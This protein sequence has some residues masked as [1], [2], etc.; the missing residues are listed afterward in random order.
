MSRFRV[1]PG[2]FACIALL[3][4]IAAVV[5]LSSHETP[6]AASVV[7]PAA[8]QSAPVV[9]AQITSSPLSPGFEFAGSV[10]DRSAGD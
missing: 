6:R 3:Q 9:S 4:L 2:M 5:L 8:A 1:T 10:G 7:A